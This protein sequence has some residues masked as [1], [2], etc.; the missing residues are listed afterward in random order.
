MIKKLSKQNKELITEIS[1]LL[2][3]QARIIE[4]EAIPD[5]ANF[6]ERMSKSLE[7]SID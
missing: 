6:A 1:L 2:L 4:G 5:R 7:R 3:D